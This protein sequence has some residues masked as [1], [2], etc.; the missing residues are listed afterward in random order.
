MNTQKPSS[1]QSAKPSPIVEFLGEDAG[2][3]GPFAI[4]GLLHDITSDEQIIR[5]CNRRLHQIDLHRHRSTPDASEVRLAVHAAASQLLDPALRSQLARRWPAGTPVAVPKAWKPIRRATKLTPKILKNARLLVAASGGWNAIARKRLAHLARMNR[6][7]ALEL[8][9][10]LSPSQQRL[11]PEHPQTQGQ[12]ALESLRPVQLV[13]P[14]PERSPQWI[15]A[16]TLLILMAGFVLTTVVM[17]PP[18]LRVS[19]K[20]RNDPGSS[21]IG[22]QSGGLGAGSDPSARSMPSREREELTHYTAVAH[23]LDQL[24]SRSQSDPL[25]SVERFATIYPKFVESWTAFPEPALQRS[26]LHIVEFT[27]RVSNQ[28]GIDSLTQIFSCGRIDDDPA[29][30]MIR[31]A[32]IDIVLAEPALSP[33]VSAELTAI[34]KRCSGNDPR[35]T[36]N[37]ISALIAAAELEGVESRTDDPR[38]WGRWVQGLLAATSED[39]SQ[40]TNL[41]LSAI[42]SRLRDPAQPGEP[43]KKTSVELI[44]AVSWRYGSPAR[45]WLLS[46]FA[47]EAVTTPRLAVLTEALATNSGAKQI[48]VQMVLNPGSTFILRQQL[49]REYSN[50]WTSPSPDSS[51][52][53]KFFALI[54]E[55]RLKESITPI[56]M[57]E[58]QGIIALVELARLNTA[59]W[60][61]DRGDQALAADMLKGVSET[62]GQTIQPELLNINTT[63]RDTRWAQEAIN[64]K[65]SSDLGALFA[66]LVQDNGPGV[67]SAHALVYLASLNPDSQI[68]SL[69]AA[70]IT[71]YK[72]RPSVLLAV[73][74]AVSGKRISSRLEQLVLRVVDKPLPPRT[75]ESWYLHTHKVLLRLVADSLAKTIDSELPSLEREIGELYYSRLVEVGSSVQPSGGAVSVARQLYHQLLLESRSQADTSRHDEGNIDKIESLNAISLARASGP[76]HQFLG[77][78]RS[79]CELLALRVDSEIPGVT[80]SVRD[81]LA[82][83]ENRLD[84]T[85]T[86]LEQIVQTERC[87]AQLWV[88]QLEGGHP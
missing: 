35:P 59:A 69:A 74:K 9:G 54:N 3:G 33:S 79:I 78:Q 44:N 4:L 23:E 88:L 38:W 64:V 75:D 24:V 47:D 76:M 57:D 2:V 51:Q 63:Q 86:V 7:S 13:D 11:H 17:A 70:Q 18:Q 83:L 28:E 40:R 87:I 8:V 41:I 46:Q 65:R 71:R 22:D 67:N 52:A 49:A 43:W 21:M 48:T 31:S 72:A 45:Y 56:Q 66:E 5:A 39:E 42:S 20:I 15:A 82:M 60:Q 6:V 19:S 77:Y 80:L 58:H 14:P 50:A 73:D 26:S 53:D 12:Q 34:R 55:L 62:I 27:R 10:A 30:S 84:Q 37:I 85:N 29:K 1:K 81:K 32:I 68:R 25:K 16:Y 36:D 61:Y